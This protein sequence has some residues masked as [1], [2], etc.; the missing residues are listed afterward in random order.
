MGFLGEHAGEKWGMVGHVPSDKR[1]DWDFPWEE[2]I[3]DKREILVYDFIDTSPGQSGS[4]LLGI[5]KCE[6][7]G[8][9]TGGS[10]SLKRNWAT[11]LTPAK[12]RWIAN[13]L[14]QEVHSDHGTLY[15]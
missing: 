15:Y 14:G 11:Y 4:P 8:V 5:L 13:T 2:E 9:H 12:L 7:I 1:N 6:V 3:K 10:D